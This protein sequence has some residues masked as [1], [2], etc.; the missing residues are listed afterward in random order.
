VYDTPT[1]KDGERVLVDRLWPRGLTK[2]R[3][4]VG[5]WLKDVAPS[6]AL[7][8]WFSHDPKRWQEFRERYFDELR[9]NPVEVRRLA[10][11]VSEGDVTL[12][13]AAHDLERNNAAALADYLA[14]LHR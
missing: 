12:L 11:L 3:A 13:F 14:S 8:T 1:P 2:Q 4:A 6:E 10:S 9:K 7:R 5:I